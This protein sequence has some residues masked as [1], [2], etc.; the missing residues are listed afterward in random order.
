[1]RHDRLRVLGP[2]HTNTTPSCPSP[3][4][5]WH[6]IR[7]TWAASVTSL[8]QLG[9]KVLIRL[10]DAGRR[11]VRISPVEA[12][13][14]HGVCHMVH[15]V[16]NRG[17]LVTATSLEHEKATRATPW[18]KALL[19]C[20]GEQAIGRRL[21]PR[22]V[23]DEDPRQGALSMRER[24]EERRQSFPSNVTT[25]VYPSFKAY[26][27]MSLGFPSKEVRRTEPQIRVSAA[28]RALR[29][30]QKKLSPCALGMG[31]AAWSPGL[32]AAAGALQH[33]GILSPGEWLHPLV[34]PAAHASDGE[35]CL[36]FHSSRKLAPLYLGG[37]I[38]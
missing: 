30:P 4:S 32:D 25:L 14:R 16:D 26:R 8:A 29:H 12:L 20:P 9:A 36:H 31:A 6:R 13:S 27:R 24:E 7:R 35:S 2:E 5:R 15:V 11:T 19:P 37:P 34:I 22:C 17:G 21:Q 18:I 10:P 3:R 33:A 1:M 28:S 38:A 23:C